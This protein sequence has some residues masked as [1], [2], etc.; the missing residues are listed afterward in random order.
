MADEFVTEMLNQVY[1]D[2]PAALDPVLA[3]LQSASI[4]RDK[5]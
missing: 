2:E 1:A 4:M 5:W 3:A